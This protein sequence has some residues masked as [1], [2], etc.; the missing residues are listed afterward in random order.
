M[1][2]RVI[3]GILEHCPNLEQLQWD[4]NT[5]PWSEIM[6]GNEDISTYLE[7]GGNNLKLLRLVNRDYDY[8]LLDQDLTEIR[9]APFRCFF[10][11]AKLENLRVDL[12]GLARVTAE[13]GCLPKSLKEVEVVV[14]C[15]GDFHRHWFQPNQDAYET[16]KS[17]HFF[18]CGE[19][20]D[21]WLSLCLVQL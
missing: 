11:F 1:S 2:I 13:V 12:E 9:S 17:D 5:V 8:D 20:R 16:P 6:T 19:L 21:T 14:P 7:P 18:D 10:S 15:E 4:L 3:R